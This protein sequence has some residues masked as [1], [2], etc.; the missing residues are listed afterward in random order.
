MEESI[1][2]TKS[3]LWSLSLRDLFYKYI[4]FLPIF[5][6]SVAIALLG[7]YAYLRYA[8]PIYS[9]TGTLIIKSDLPNAR[10]D[11]FDDIFG[12]GG[13]GKSQNIQN[14]IEV[15]KSKGLMSRVVEKLNLQYSYYVKGKIK[16][17]NIYKFGPFLIEASEIIDSSQAFT[18]KIKFVNDQAFKVNNDNT[19][20]GFGR[21]FKNQFG[22]FRLIRQLGPVSKDYTIQYQPTVAAASLYAGSLLVTPKSVGTGILNITMQSAHPNLGADVVNQLLEE[23]GDYTKELKNKTADQMLDFIDN[24]LSVIKRELD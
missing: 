11:K 13:S 1:K 2:T 3:E 24:R 18:L 8:T 15:L 4:R 21:Y 22:T 17:I 16:T 7:A 19:V 14:E 20:I 6:L 9:T 12:G 5:V 23:Y 10:G